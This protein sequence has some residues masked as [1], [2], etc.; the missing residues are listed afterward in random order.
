[1][2]NLLGLIALTSLA[3]INT[4]QAEGNIENGRALSTSC[5]ACHGTNGMST[6][7]QYPNIAGQRESYLIKQLENYQSGDRADPTMQALVGPL[8]AQDIQ[9]LAAYFASNSAVA[10]YSFD[11]ETLAIPYVDVGGTL[12][13]VEMSLDTLEPIVFTVTGLEPL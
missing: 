12:F 4:A 10:S 13:N 3:F 5:S 8:N 7:E 9:D 2:K 11:T 1:M 6:S